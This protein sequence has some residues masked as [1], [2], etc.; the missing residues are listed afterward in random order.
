MDPAA[1][2]GVGDTNRVEKRSGGLRNAL[3]RMNYGTVPVTPVARD[4]KV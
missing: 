4:L 2:L 1:Y 3:A